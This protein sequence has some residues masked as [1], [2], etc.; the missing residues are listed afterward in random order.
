MLTIYFVCQIKMVA[1]IFYVHSF[2]LFCLRT[3]H[4]I[5]ESS[6]ITWLHPNHLAYNVFD[7][8]T[9]ILYAI[10]NDK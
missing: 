4:K 2:F 7:L 9:F 6:C 3:W 5:Y 8:F 10:L 1:H